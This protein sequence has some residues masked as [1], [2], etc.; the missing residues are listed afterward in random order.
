MLGQL[1]HFWK[2]AP[3]DVPYAKKRYLNEGK[4]CTT[5]IIAAVPLTVMLR[6]K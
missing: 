1:G 5:V 4:R 2:F 6:L 3:E